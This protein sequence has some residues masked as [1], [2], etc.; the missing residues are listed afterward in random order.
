MQ[1]NVTTKRDFPH[2]YREFGQEFRSDDACAVYLEQL[3]G[4]RASAALHVRQ[5]ECLGV[6][7]GAVW[8]VLRVATRHP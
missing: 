7:R 3:R 6:R 4:Q 5:V 1:D 8:S 2:T